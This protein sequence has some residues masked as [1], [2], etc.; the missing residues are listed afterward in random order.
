MSEIVKYIFLWPAWVTLHSDL[1]AFHCVCGSTSAALLM[2][3]SPAPWLGY[4][5]WCCDKCKLP[6]ICLGTYPRQAQ[7]HHWWL[8]FSLFWKNLHPVFQN[9]CTN[10]HSRQTW[11][12]FFLYSPHAGTC[13]HLSFFGGVG[14]QC[15]DKL[16]TLCSLGLHSLCHLSHALS[17]SCFRL[18]LN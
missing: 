5:E 10:L 16:R 11:P 6:F 9:G 13:Y 12:G 18:F 8:H 1:C 14:G 15:W 3:C 4:C 2:G 7:L 17:S